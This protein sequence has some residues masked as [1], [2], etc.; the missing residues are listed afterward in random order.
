L[1]NASFITQVKLIISKQE[2]LSN[3]H[4]QQHIKMNKMKVATKNTF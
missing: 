2:T 3:K 1:N 4:S